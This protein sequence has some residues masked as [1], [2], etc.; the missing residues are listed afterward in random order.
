YPTETDPM[1]DKIKAG[2]WQKKDKQYN[3]IRLLATTPFS[4]VEQGE[5][6]WFTPEYY[7][8]G[9]TT[10][11]CQAPMK[12][13]HISHFL[14]KPLG[15]LYYGSQT[16]FFQQ[17]EASY[18]V[19]GDT[20]YN[21]KNNGAIVPVGEYGEV[22]DQ[23]NPH[24]YAQSLAFSQSVPLIIM[25][26]GPSVEVHLKI[27]TF[28]SGLR[29]EFYR[30]VIDTNSSFVKYQLEQTRM[31]N[32]S[33]AQNPIIS[34]FLPH[35]AAR[36]IVITTTGENFTGI[37]LFHEV[38]WVTVEDYDYNINIPS[39]QYITEDAQAA[40]HAVNNYLP[41]IWRPDTSYYVKLTLKDSI[42]NGENEAF[43]EYA[44]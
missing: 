23:S 14:D 35:R 16:N 34:S 18:Q 4:Y 2:Q 27:T 7:G 15:T 22:T 21:V 20:T 43:Y 3:A 32:S 38:K 37:N 11:F 9:P 40:A 39:Q 1:V 10:L 13:E 30:S 31:V 28:N 44:Y 5:P 17:M 12:V 41:P 8:V 42:D 6:S 33:Q 26:S 29:I 24:G 25:L 19:F 36:K